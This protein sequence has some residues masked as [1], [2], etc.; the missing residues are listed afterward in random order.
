MIPEPNLWKNTDRSIDEVTANCND[1]RHFRHSNNSN[2]SSSTMTTD[3]C[4]TLLRNSSIDPGFKEEM[5]L[6]QQQQVSEKKQ[7][8]TTYYWCYF[9]CCHPVSAWSMD[10]RFDLQRP[11]H[12]E[13]PRRL[14]WR[15]QPQLPLPQIMQSELDN[16]GT[17]LV[18]HCLACCFSEWWGQWSLV[19]GRCHSLLLIPPHPHALA[20]LPPDWPW[21]YFRLCTSINEGESAR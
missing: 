13:W 2:T 9:K 12:W 14:K 16:K 8:L 21:I 4:R 17:V 10:Q 7:D 3:P 5:E 18:L 6:H 1:I 19:N 20:R 11:V 15:L